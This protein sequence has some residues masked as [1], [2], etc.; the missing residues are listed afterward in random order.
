MDA[1]T[2]HLAQGCASLCFL[3]A[4]KTHLSPL[5]GTDSLWGGW[6]RTTDVDLAPALDALDP[7][8]LKPSCCSVHAPWY[9]GKQV[10]AAVLRPA[11]QPNP[12]RLWPG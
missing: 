5:A 6:Q 10:A 12:G 8:A 11:Q 9:G 4:S 2:P 3:R 7:C 1:A